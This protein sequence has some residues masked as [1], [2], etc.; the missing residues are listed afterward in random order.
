M[1]IAISLRWTA[2]GPDATTIHAAASRANELPAV[3]LKDLDDVANFHDARGWHFAHAKL[4]VK[5]FVMLAVNDNL[6]DRK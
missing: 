1:V 6:C 3:V 4:L 2:I 5:I